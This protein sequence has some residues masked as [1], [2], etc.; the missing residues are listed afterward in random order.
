MSDDLKK[1]KKLLKQEKNIDKQC[2]YLRKIIEYYL[3]NQLLDEMYKELQAYNNLIENNNLQNH[4]LN[5]YYLLGSYYFYIN[6]TDQAL[7]YFFKAVDLSYKHP[8]RLYL[9]RLFY[10]IAG[11]YYR[12][13]NS[14]KTLEY[15]EKA[16]EIAKEEKDYYQIITIYACVSRVY[17]DSNNAQKALEYLDKAKKMSI[18][19]KIP[20]FDFSINY[21]LSILYHNLLDDNQKALS[22]INEAMK[23][24][25]KVDLL[26][27]MVTKSAILGGLNL[28]DEC[29]KLSEEIIEICDKENNLELKSFTLYNTAKVYEKIGNYKKSTELFNLFFEIYASLNE[30]KLTLTREELK[31]KFEHLNN[32]KEKEIYKLKN[33][34]LKNALKESISLTKKLK[35]KNDENERLI[36]ILTHELANP[37]QA[38]LTSNSLLSDLDLDKNQAK[39]LNTIKTM[40]NSILDT[41]SHVKELISIEKGLLH[42]EL[43]NV[44]LKEI[45]DNTLVLFENLLLEKNL[46][47]D[48]I[49]NVKLDDLF[50]RAEPVSLQNCVINN[51][52]SNAIKYSFPDKSIMLVINSENEWVKI[53]IIDQGIGIKS[54]D[55]KKI[56]KTDNP[57]INKGTFGE[58]GLGFGMQLTNKYLQHYNGKISVSSVHID[59]DNHKHGSK[60]TIQLKRAL[61]V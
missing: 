22:H 57:Q 13:F 36:R 51:L 24:A 58:S 29:I 31:A 33:I 49:S 30:K 20:D 32:E 3:K 28:D 56:F 44:S 1:I 59:N 40:T 60:V 18:E 45:I 39:H 17:A 48:I 26:N 46:K 52:I 25:P 7:Y 11:I 37:L 38:I 12:D 35:I 5:Y 34:D 19:K 6:D 15:S 8:E 42:V 10:L 16:L 50:V 27:A 21:N 53:D 47:L 55:L 14:E 54:K 2:E 4:L 43:K 23:I 61:K 41:L 9:S